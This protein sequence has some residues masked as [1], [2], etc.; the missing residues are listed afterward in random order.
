VIFGIWW[1]NRC[2][3]KA[4]LAGEGYGDQQQ[5]DLGGE[6]KQI[7]LFN[8]L[9][10]I[11]IAIGVNALLTYLVLPHL[12]LTFLG[13]KRFGAVSPKSVIGLW[14]ILIALLCACLWLILRNWK[15]W[16][17]L[18]ESINNGCR[19]ALFPM[20]STGSEV[21]YGSVIAGLAGFTLLKDSVMSLSPNNPIISEAISV[22]VL[23]AIT[24]SSSGGMSIA[25]KT[26]G[27]DY[28][29]MASNLGMNPELLH[30]VATLASSGLD[31]LPHS[32]SVITLLLIGKLTHRQCYPA[33]FMVTSA[34]PSLA[35]VLVLILGS[36]FGSF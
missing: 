7:S 6:G 33:I 32:A 11:A 21:G 17:N 26:L 5:E 18:K 8:A 34:G 12:D 14:S 2:V 16:D 30:R 9:S 19:S 4:S 25:L 1:L 3:R 31:T 36:I 10:P 22:Y 29:A 27:A 15:T 20:I 28:A 13:E 35:L 24:A 23:S